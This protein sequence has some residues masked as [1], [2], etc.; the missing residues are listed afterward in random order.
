LSG[1]DIWRSIGEALTW[2]VFRDRDAVD[3]VGGFPLP[4]Y[5]PQGSY[6]LDRIAA[7]SLHSEPQLLRSDGMAF[8]V[9]ES[10]SGA[11]HKLIAQLR[12]GAVR[13]R[14][15]A[16]P[17]ESAAVDI[18]SWSHWTIMYQDFTIILMDDPKFPR[19]RDIEF[20][21][22]DLLQVWPA[23]GGRGKATPKT[24]AI[25]QAI[26]SL[27]PTGT[28]PMLNKDRDAQISEWCRTNR[29]FQIDPKTIER[30]FKARH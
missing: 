5:A 4:E 14:Q 27:W 26:R 18:A 28:P 17:A 22:F 29:G 11:P 25:L 8:P 16:P 15:Q 12:Q 1:L 24:T 3:M 30:L 2:I 7:A 20:H 10:P 6:L 19:R 9:H 13:A 23:L 21:D